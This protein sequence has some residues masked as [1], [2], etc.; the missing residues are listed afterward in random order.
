MCKRQ[1]QA[2]RDLEASYQHALS[3]GAIATTAVQPTSL[4]AAT[5]GAAREHEMAQPAATGGAAEETL[6]QK[7]AADAARYSACKRGQLLPG[8]F[9]TSF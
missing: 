6:R 3:L 1:M 5:V 2:L 4:G 8:S 7:V 9:A